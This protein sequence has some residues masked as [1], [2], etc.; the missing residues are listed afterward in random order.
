VAKQ[1]KTSADKNRKRK[2]DEIIRLRW[3]ACRVVQLESVRAGLAAL[4][5]QRV[6]GCNQGFAGETLITRI[7]AA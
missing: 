6:P 3:K 7:K 2:V 4:W 1:T 5:R